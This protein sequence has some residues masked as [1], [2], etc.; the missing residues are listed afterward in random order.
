VPGE[1]SDGSRPDPLIDEIHEIRRKI[2]ERFGHDVKRLGQHYMEMQEQEPYRGRLVSNGDPA[3]MQPDEKAKGN[4]PPE[5]GAWLE[6]LEEI[7]EIRRQ[8]LAE[9]DNDFGRM[10]HT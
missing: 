10:A 1:A 2:S 6:P 4:P 3:P 9:F 7:W 5:Q 8:L